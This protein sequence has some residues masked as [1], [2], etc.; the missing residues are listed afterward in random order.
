[1]LLKLCLRCIWIL[2]L[3]PS[4]C[5]NSS[6]AIAMLMLRPA[7][8]SLEYPAPIDM[9]SMKL[10]RA[11]PNIIMYA[12]VALEVG[13]SWFLACLLLGCNKRM[14]LICGLLYI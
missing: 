13:L 14:N 9:P 6:H 5:G 10:C 8:R 12:T 4:S 7:F 11:S 1:M 2:C 3:S